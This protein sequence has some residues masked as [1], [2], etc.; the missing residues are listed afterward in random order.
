LKHSAALLIVFFNFCRVHLANG[1][2]PAQAVGI[3]D[4][5]WTVEELLKTQ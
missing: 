4:H 2:T 1:K 3:K 5:P